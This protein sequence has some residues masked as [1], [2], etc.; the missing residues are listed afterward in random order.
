M[1]LS[2]QEIVGNDGM[3]K[4][5][6][7]F[8]EM[9][10][11]II[12]SVISGDSTK[13]TARKLRMPESFIRTFLNKPKVKAYIKEQKELAAELVQVK[14]QGLL[15]DILE[16]RIEACDGDIGRLTN[17][18]TLDVLKL[19]QEVSSGISKASQQS[20]T[21]DKYAAILGLVLKDAK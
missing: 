3:D 8:T 12:V 2:K 1:I 7:D 16:E 15:T 13:M 10:T 9:E 14:I 4:L 6:P 18:D 17:K 5:L 11:S 20:E 19:L 21:E